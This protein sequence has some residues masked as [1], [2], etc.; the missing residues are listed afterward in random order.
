MLVLLLTD[1]YVDTRECLALLVLTHQQK[2]AIAHLR[3]IDEITEPEFQMLMN[4]V[5][6]WP[7]YSAVMSN[8]V[9]TREVDWAIL[10]SCLSD[11]PL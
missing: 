10:M 2:S 9:R 1:S 6:S 7:V 8:W 5:E 4:S 3:S 11:R